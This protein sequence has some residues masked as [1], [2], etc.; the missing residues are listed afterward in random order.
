ME[1][2][3]LSVCTLTAYGD[4]VETYKRMLKPPATYQAS[5]ALRSS[6]I[7]NGAQRACSF[8]SPRSQPCVLLCRTQKFFQHSLLNRQ[9][10]ILIYLTLC[11]FHFIFTFW[12]SVFVYF[13]SSFYIFSL[14]HSTLVHAPGSVYSC[15]HLLS[16][17]SWR[18]TGGGQKAI[19]S[20]QK[21]LTALL[22]PIYPTQTHPEPHISP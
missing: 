22:I 18:Q 14:S 13:M 4:A 19:H 17:P 3:L 16:S 6:C 1:A 8:E 7:M 20:P 10:Y 21:R 9:A 15:P 2:W 5:S 12:T 11:V